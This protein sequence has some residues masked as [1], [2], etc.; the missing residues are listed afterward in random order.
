VLAG[1]SALG[2]QEEAEQLCEATI[3]IV[4]LWAIAIAFNPFRMLCEKRV[5]HP[6][7]QRGIRRSFNRAT[8]KTGRVHCLTPNV[9]ALRNWIEDPIPAAARVKDGHVQHQHRVCA[10]AVAREAIF[11]ISSDPCHAFDYFLSLGSSALVANSTN[12][13]AQK[14]DVMIMAPPHNRPNRRRGYDRLREC[15]G[16]AQFSKPVSREWFES[17]LLPFGFDLNG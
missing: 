17:A 7:L 4:A 13:S 5:V 9:L 6:A 10:D 2:R 14:I 12:T 15:K 16:Q 11:A 8:G 1:L 3:V